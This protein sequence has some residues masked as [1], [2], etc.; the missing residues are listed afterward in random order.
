MTN[1]FQVYVKG[2]WIL[3]PIGA[4][5]FQAPHYDLLEVSADAGT[6]R[7]WWWILGT[8]V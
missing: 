1:A 7:Q 2:D 8:N 6:I 3:I 5:L 4:I